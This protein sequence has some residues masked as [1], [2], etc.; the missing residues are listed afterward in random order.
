MNIIIQKTICI[1]YIDIDYKINGEIIVKIIFIED[2]I[3]NIKEDGF[4][5]GFIEIHILLI[6]II[7]Q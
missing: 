3:K 2:Y 4:Y 6:I 1:I 7:A 5:G